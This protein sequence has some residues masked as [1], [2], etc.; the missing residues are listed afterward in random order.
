MKFSNDLFSRR[1]FLAG[2]GAAA[3][4]LT[5]APVSSF[6]AS[7]KTLNFLN[8][9]T[10]I[11]DTTLDDFHNVSGIKVNMELFPD[12]EALYD[13]LKDGNSVYDLIVPTD[14]TTDRLIQE[15]RLMPLDYS[16]IPN[17]KNIEPRFQDAAFD[18]GRKYSITYMW[19][20]IGI[21][22]RK[23][24]VDEPID[25][26]KWLY[27][28]DKYSGKIAL[29]GEGSTT[30]QMALKYLGYSLNTTNLA[31]LKAAEELIIKQKPHIV[32]FAEDNGQDLL[33]SGQVDI[34]MEWNGD[35][36]QTM[37]E[38]NDIG[39]AVPQEGGLLWQDNL[40]IPVN[41]P[42]PET[43]HQFINFLLDA[44]IGADLARYIQYATPNAAA[45]ELMDDE[46]LNNP[47]I[48]PPDEVVARSEAAPYLGADYDR[49]LNE[50]WIRINN[51]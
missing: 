15:D 16:L 34:V 5:F 50:T 7:G 21:G 12:N 18:P 4:G 48:F 23:S 1:S 10:Y 30:I 33:L 37:L 13:K 11:G 27:D 8:W 31:H 43:A 9:D 17:A 25:S 24:Q 14:T 45:K 3:A 36:L 20:T 29:M 28:S 49:L 38:D 2:T 32:T 42:H 40:S 47:A 39:Y 51:A 19:G 6:S 41:A 22:Y 46:Y 44:E 35:I 26:W